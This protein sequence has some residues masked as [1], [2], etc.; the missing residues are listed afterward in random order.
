[1]M[2]PLDYWSW[3]FMQFHY[4]LIYALFAGRIEFTNRTA[5]WLIFLVNWRNMRIQRLHHITFSLF[6]L[7]SPLLAIRCW[8]VVIEALQISHFFEFLALW[9]MMLWVVKFDFWVKLVSPFFIS[10]IMGD[11]NFGL[12]FLYKFNSFNVFPG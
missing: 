6:F 4:M 8:L 10:D 5:K 3:I 9:T 11:G 1:M 2:H 7:F 12:E